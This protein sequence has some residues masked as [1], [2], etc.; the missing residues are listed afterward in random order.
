MP[1]GAFRRKSSSGHRRRLYHPSHGPR[2]GDDM[3]AVE[4]NEPYVGKV[5]PARRI[6]IEARRLADY[7]AGLEL[8]APRDGDFVPSMFAMQ[9]DG[10]T[11]V[12]FS[13]HFGH[14]WLLQ[15]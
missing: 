4:A 5:V 6:S 10:A 8:E 3:P 9:A 1:A 7:Y 11:R 12:L 13:E 15:E 2:G 14:L